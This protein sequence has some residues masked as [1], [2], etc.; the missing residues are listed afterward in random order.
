MS[1]SSG[2]P[3]GGL[4]ARTLCL[5]SLAGEV[6]LPWLCGLHPL[7]SLG[8]CAT[9]V[10]W[11]GLLFP[12]LPPASCFRPWAPAPSC[13]YS[14][15]CGGQ[16]Q[17]HPESFGT[18]LPTSGSLPTVNSSRTQTPPAP[19][20]AAQAV[21]RI[22]RQR[23]APAAAA[24]RIQTLTTQYGLMPGFFNHPRAGGL[25]LVAVGR[26]EWVAFGFGP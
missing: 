11:G 14:V 2:F 23:T 1:G 6:G 15:E 12:W 20:S 19:W 16:G 13:L 24:P 25:A 4:A 3:G 18:A 21:W 17:R 7:L 9:L 10:G 26:E 5:H 22:G 8:R